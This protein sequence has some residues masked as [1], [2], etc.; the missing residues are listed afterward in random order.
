MLDVTISTAFAAR[1]TMSAEEK[2]P[3]CHVSLSQACH[4]DRSV[5]IF[6]IQGHNYSLFVQHSSRVI[7]W[8]QRIASPTC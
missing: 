7:F 3:A 8:A 4:S 2:K 5:F 1:C 6:I